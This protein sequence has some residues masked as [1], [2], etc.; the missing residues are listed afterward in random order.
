[1]RPQHLRTSTSSTHRQ[2]LTG[3]RDTSY[4]V[5]KGQALAAPNLKPTKTS[6]GDLA[7][8]HRQQK[9]TQT[10]CK[11]CYGATCAMSAWF[12]SDRARDQLQRCGGQEQ[13]LS[14][15]VVC[16]RSVCVLDIERATSAAHRYRTQPSVGRCA[17]KVRRFT[18]K[19]LY[20]TFSQPQ[21]ET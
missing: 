18:N 6:C 9:S 13:N 20:K 4:N 7:T 17:C 8:R 19:T 14:G 21:A 5:R 12:C 15:K 1:M 11:M 3:R 10:R 16:A 2:G